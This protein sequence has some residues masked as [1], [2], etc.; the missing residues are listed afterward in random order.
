MSIL[1]CRRLHGL[2]DEVAG[3]QAVA[4]ALQTRGDPAQIRHETEIAG[5]AL[6]VLNR[7]TGHAG[8]LLYQCYL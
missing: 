2:A 3:V 5:L 1:L 4:E 8:G 6:S 7:L